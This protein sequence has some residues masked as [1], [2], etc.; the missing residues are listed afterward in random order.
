MKY[1]FF[2][3]QAREYVITRPDTP[4]SWT[5]YLGTTEYGAIVTQNAGGY[6]F[7][8]SAAQGRFMRFRSN[9][10]PA[11]QPGRYF[12]LRDRD[13]GDFW[14]SS[15]QPVGKTAGALLVGMPAR[16]G[17]H[18]HHLGVGAA[19]GPSR[20]TLSRSGQTFEYWRLRV[21]NRGA[22]PRKL[23]VFT[24]CEFT[25]NWTMSQDLV[26]L[27]Y[28]AYIV[29]A[30]RFA[31]GC[32]G[33]SINDHLPVDPVH[34]TNNDQSRHSVDGRSP[35]RTVAAHDFDR[36]AFL[37]RYGSYAAPEAVVR[38]ACGNHDAF[39]DNACGAFQMDLDL[40][41]GETRELLVL[42][43]VGEAESRRPGRAGRI[44]GNAARCERELAVLKA[45]WHAK[46]GAVQVRSPDPAF[47]SMVNVWNAY[48]SL[49]TY[50]WSRAASLVYNGERD[51][52]GYRD[53]VQDILGVLPMIPDEARQRL[54]LML[55]GQLSHGGA[56]PVVKPFAHRPGR[57]SGPRART[58]ALGRLPM[59]LQHRAR[60]RGGERRPGVL[61]QGAAVR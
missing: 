40:A 13:T 4:R 37:G 24:Y 1:G 11:D 23:S 47:D 21:T 5:N 31:A 32:C 55:T 2:D 26:N 56:M 29:R 3:D 12:Y 16:H 50:A 42:L 61:P 52:L 44:Y 41:P 15:W 8:R 48:N 20:P 43:G 10:V 57:E 54:E 33:S 58:P 49:I 25:S 28:S 19:S 27:Q 6:S 7:Y 60:L 45:G 9:T 59:A 18:R 34:F 22:A 36:D 39:A 35:A 46:L 17:L 53:T 14:S 51:G 38:G 30:E